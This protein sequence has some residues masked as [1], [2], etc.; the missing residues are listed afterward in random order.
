MAFASDVKCS[1]WAMIREP[2]NPLGKPDILTLL[3]NH[4]ILSSHPV[5][6]VKR[7]LHLSSN[8]PGLVD[9]ATLAMVLR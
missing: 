6:F 7:Q 8:T 9:Y 4:G 5:S 1:H 3:A 2:L